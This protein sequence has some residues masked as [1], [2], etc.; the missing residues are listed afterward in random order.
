MTRTYLPAY[1]EV[2]TPLL[3]V[4]NMNCL[5]FVYRAYHFEGSTVCPPSEPLLFELPEP[6]VFVVDVACA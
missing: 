1:W 6:E 4:K 2:R 3:L 5:S